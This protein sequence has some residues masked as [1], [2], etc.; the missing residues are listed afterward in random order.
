MTESFID[1]SNKEKKEILQTEA[2]RLGKSSAIL[3]KTS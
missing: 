3:E 1:L 2:P